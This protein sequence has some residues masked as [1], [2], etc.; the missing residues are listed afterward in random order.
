MDMIDIVLILLSLCFAF[1]NMM[2]GFAESDTNKKIELFFVSILCCF[3]IMV[4]L[5]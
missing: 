3:L 2:F 5:R 4:V 1:I